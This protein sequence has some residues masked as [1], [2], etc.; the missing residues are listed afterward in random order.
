MRRKLHWSDWNPGLDNDQLTLQQVLSSMP[1]A[2]PEAIPW[3]VRV[4]EN[5]LSAL[6][7]PGAVSLTRHDAIHALLGRGL[8]NQDE[9]FVIGYTMGA[10]S[11]IRDWQFA[12]F[13]FAALRLYPK[14]YRFSASDLVAFDLGYS[15]GRTGK[16]RDLQEVPF[17]NLSEH[18]LA[19]LRRDIGI[20]VHSLH[21]AYRAE[22]SRIPHTPASR[23]LDQDF[24]GVDPSD[25]HPPQGTESDWKRE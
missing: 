14:T 10:A 13:R 2:A 6:A 5:P 21:A 3:Q 12:V 9:A 23:R 22:A 18:T 11:N 20:D 4:L 25:L 7:F 1:A 16:A 8:S 19:Q 17:E 15:Q 24:R